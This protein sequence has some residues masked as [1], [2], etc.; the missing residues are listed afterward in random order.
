MMGGQEFGYSVTLSSDGDRV[1]VGAPS[2]STSPDDGKCWAWES[3][4]PPGEFCE[5]SGAAYVFAFDSS[6]WYPEAYIKDQAKVMWGAFGDTVIFSDSG[7][8]L[9][10]G[11]PGQI[12]VNPAEIGRVNIYKFDADEWAHN[13]SLYSY[14][15]YWYHATFIDLLA[16]SGDGT[17]LATVFALEVGIEDPNETP[18]YECIVRVYRYEGL[19]WTE[20]DEI[21][22]DNPR[23]RCNIWQ[24]HG[25]I[26]WD[27]NIIAA[28]GYDDAS[29]AVGIGGDRSNTAAEESGAVDVIKFNGQE[30]VT[31]YVNASNTG[32][33]DSFGRS[34]ALSADGNT[35]VIGAGGE[36]SGATGING[37]QSDNSAESSGAVYVY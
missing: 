4:L 35:L 1:A 23:Y 25:D 18:I 36:D 3:W 30:W 17:T 33:F 26:S 12:T 24:W 29:D 32:A 6:G 7:D 14:L 8:V 16:L 34:V 22:S 19:E 9:A 15:D 20:Q 21:W 28:G 31:T 27:G 2:E 37:D 13:A 10:I 5:Y 11:A